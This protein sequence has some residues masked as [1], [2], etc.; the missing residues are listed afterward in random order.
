MMKQTF[1]F[2]IFILLVVACKGNKVENTTATT[3]QQVAVADTDS[4]Q[5]ENEPPVAADGFF[6]DFFFNFQTN[7][8]FQL[9]RVSFPLLVQEGTTTQQL[10]KKD[11]KFN[12][13][14]S[15]RELYTMLFDNKSELKT[16]KDTALKVVVVEMINLK[17]EKVAQ[18]FFEK[19]R[20]QW[21]LTSLRH[22]SLQDNVNKDFYLFY[23]DFAQKPSFRLTHVANPFNLVVIDP[24]TYKPLRGV[25]DA[26]QW[27]DYCPDLPKIEITNIVYRQR[28]KDPRH[29]VLVV[30]SIN[31]AMNSVISFEKTKASWRAIKLENN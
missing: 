14:Y 23:R 16:A 20:K 31:G 21:M 11:W 1:G 13:F 6:D 8:A 28:Y 22:Q 12:P 9:K 29:R 27:P 3:A 18:Y 4:L 25:A 19:L 7:Q 5:S 10:E 15:K 26:G 17:T 2:L 24:D 30:S